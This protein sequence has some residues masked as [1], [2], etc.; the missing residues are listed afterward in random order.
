MAVSLHDLNSLL[1]E[2]EGER[3]EFKSAQRNYPFDR[4]VEYCAAIANEG[5]GK[6]VL[7]VTDRRPREVVGTAAFDEPGRTVAGLM[8]RL[9]IRVSVS[10][11]QH[12]DGRVLVFE[13]SGRPVGLPVG[14]DGRYFARSGDALR[15]MTQEELRQIFDEAGPD[16][17]AQIEPEATLDHLDPSTIELFRRQWRN[18][19]Q[20][21]ALDS[22]SAERLLADAELLIDGKVTRAAL[23][24]LGTKTALGRFIPQAEVVFE[25]RSSETNISHQQ[26][27]EYRQGFLSFLDD[28]WNTINLR[29]EVIQY[30]DGLFRRDLPVMNETVVREAVLNALAHRDYRLPGSIFIRQFP[31][32]LEIVSPGGLP[33]GITVENIFR[34]QFPRNRRIAEACA[35]C[36]LVERSGQGVDRMIEESLREGKPRPDFK[37]TDE[38]EVSLTIRGEVKNPAFIRFLERVSSE[39]QVS[40]SLEDLM[41]LDLLQNDQPITSELRTNLTHLVD[42]GVVE[43]VGRGR[44]VRYVLSRKFYSFLGKPGAYTREKGL[45]RET[46]KTLLLKHITDSGSNGSALNELL[47]VLPSHSKDQVKKLLQ[48]L[49]DEGKISPAGAKRGAKWFAA[50]G[51]YGPNRA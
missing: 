45:D 36:G 42:Q 12:P 10:E 18:K 19:S 35:R 51:G 39:Q 22:L 11:I 28:V 4:L 13:V 50:N 29:N 21:P 7:G 3:L 15:A 33:N 38:Y 41:L 17:S 27:L 48:Q 8:E 47:Q 49:K 32:K 26:R 16:F 40:F 5:G 34:K 31:R 20:N 9:R 6:I 14:V 37:G 30:Q 23:I 1:S 25:Y 44:G 43:R 46:N 24:F 2:P